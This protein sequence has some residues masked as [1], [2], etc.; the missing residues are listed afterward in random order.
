MNDLLEWKA[1]LPWVKKVVLVP[2]ILV[3]STVLAKNIENKTK[4][5]RN[6][7]NQWYI[8]MIKE[9]SNKQLTWTQIIYGKG[10]HFCIKDEKIKL[11]P[12]IWCQRFSFTISLTNSHTI[13]TIHPLMV[14]WVFSSTFLFL[15]SRKIVI[16]M[17]SGNSYALWPNS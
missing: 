6:K 17:F 8:L 12:N 15:V 5:E 2:H 9:T 13:S 1:L 10:K 16:W 3:R 7:I 11:Q 14:K 4:H